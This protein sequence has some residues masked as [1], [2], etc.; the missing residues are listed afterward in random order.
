MTA[1][2]TRPIVRD[3]AKASGA[4]ST[5]AGVHTWK[6]TADESGGAFFLFEDQ[7]TRGR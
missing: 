7:M 4:G 1:T 2:V 6:V 5:A 3:A